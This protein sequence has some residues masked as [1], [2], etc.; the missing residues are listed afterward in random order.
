MNKTFLNSEIIEFSTFFITQKSTLRKTAKHFN[1]SKST[2]HNLFCKKLK[3]ISYGL[4]LKTKRRLNINK[5]EKHIRGGFAT[6]Q[7][8]KTNPKKQKSG[9]SPL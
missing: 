8:F 5:T 4:F 6:K 9:T 1:I 7:K 2:L 3:K